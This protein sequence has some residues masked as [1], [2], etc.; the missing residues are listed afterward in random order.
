MSLLHSL[1]QHPRLVSVL[2]GL[3]MFLMLFILVQKETFPS[4]EIEIF[5]KGQAIAKGQ[6][7]Y[8]DIGSQHMPLM[9]Y[10]AAFFSLISISSV[11]MFRV[12]FYALFAVLWTLMFHRYGKWYGRTAIGLYPM[13]YIAGIS[14]IDLGWC[15]LSE[16]LQGIGLVILFYELIHFY[17]T[18]TLPLLSNF[19]ISLAIV[20]SFGST[21]VSIF[22]IFAVWLTVFVL[23]IRNAR[24]NH[25]RLLAF[26]AYLFRKYWILIVFI[27][28]PF[29]MLFAYYAAVGSLEDFIGWAYTLNRTVYPRY[30]DQAY[31]SNI[32]SSMF[33]GVYY[34]GQL[35]IFSS[36]STLS[37]VV[38]V[39]LVLAGVAFLCD[40][41]RSK[42]DL[43]LVFG[44]IFLVVTSASRG[45][46]NFHGL[47]CVAILA[48]MLALLIGHHGKQFVAWMRP[49]VMRPAIIAGIVCTLFAQWLYC[50]PTSFSTSLADAIPVVP[51]TYQWAIQQ[52]TY[53]GE[54][55]GFTSLSFEYIQA[56]GVTFA[57]ATTGSTP[58]MWEWAGSEAMDEL[59]DNP[60][61][62]FLFYPDW[63]VWGYRLE[64]YAPELLSFVENN[65]T[66]LEGGGYSVLWVRNDYYDEALEL[67]GLNI[68]LA[69]PN[70]TTSTV[71]L[72]DE[73]TVSQTFVASQDCSIASIRLS[74]QVRNSA[75]SSD[76]TATIPGSLLVS[77]V[78]EQTGEQ[79]HLVA[80]PASDLTGEY[81]TFIFDDTVELSAGTSYR[82][83]L[84]A[85][86]LGH[87]GSI[88]VACTD[89]TTNT[90]FQ[91]GIYLL[92]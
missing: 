8:T 76:E 55:I 37:Q 69:A 38:T 78:N 54:P 36:S 73:A 17:D 52:L 75:Y 30:V 44:L 13:F 67:L 48:A 16:Q 50:L 63:E 9:Y 34:V 43:I 84:T 72:T 92:G 3:C 11:P 64:D 62:L 60:P 23:E 26:I 21:F 15:I 33:Q 65:Y 56:T 85:T 18:R 70:T 47:S 46:S 2:Y 79:Q 1:K 81:S 59:Q 42:K 20:I 19:M 45:I 4:D 68:V 82:L 31:G 6:L 57:T 10:L 51:G 90:S 22:S 91:L 53:D 7:L 83:E 14:W 40:I 66:R 74:A 27:L 87:N 89:T 71:E 39:F 29:L 41:Y 12:A 61:R 35:F 88:Q 5:A 24:A 58:W 25:R 80:I 77:V 49:N 32:L 86:G 28:I